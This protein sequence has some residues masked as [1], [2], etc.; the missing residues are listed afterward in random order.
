MLTGFAYLTTTATNFCTHDEKDRNDVEKEVGEI[1]CSP[2]PPSL[3][4]LQFCPFCLDGSR[5]FGHYEYEGGQSQGLGMAK[6]D[7]AGRK[8]MGRHLEDHNRASG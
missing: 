5:G 8:S 7:L 2:S 1:S 6:G 4:Y 3:R